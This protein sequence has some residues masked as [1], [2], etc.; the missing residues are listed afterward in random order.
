MFHFKIWPNRPKKV[1][2]SVEVYF[3][4]VNNEAR[5]E[6]RD[7]CLL[8]KDFCRVYKR[9]GDVRLTTCAKILLS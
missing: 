3:V 2:F 4:E 5:V 8:R 6:T 9:I 7:F 1:I